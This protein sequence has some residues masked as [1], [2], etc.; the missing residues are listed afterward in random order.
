MVRHLCPVLSHPHPHCLSP[1]LVA[2][3]WGDNIAE[4]GIGPHL[5]HSFDQ[6]DGEDGEEKA[7]D[8]LK[9][10]AVVCSSQLF[11]I[12]YFLRE[13]VLFYY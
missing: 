11:I 9:G 8:E 1:S 10:D 7:G 12:F 5:V 3:R 13:P 2:I 4:C 6:A